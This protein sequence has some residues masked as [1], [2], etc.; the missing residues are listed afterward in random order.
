MTHRLSFLALLAVLASGCTSLQS[1][2]VSSVPKDRSRPVFASEDNV[3]FL[4]IH[5]DN[6]FVDALPDRL[7]EQCPGGKVTGVFTK[8]ESTWY[9]LVQNREVTITGYCVKGQPGA[10]V[11]KQVVPDPPPA[12]LPPPDP[13]PTPDAEDP[14]VPPEPEPPL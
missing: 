11:A 14:A 4:G 1:V 2:S 9:V 7:R 5:F 12:P 10:K 13:I 6:E 3:A 8:H